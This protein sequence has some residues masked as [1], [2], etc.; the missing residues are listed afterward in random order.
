MP[1][2]EANASRFELHDV[3]AV[4]YGNG[5]MLALDAQ[6]AL[7]ACG[8]GT[9]QY[10][11]CSCVGNSEAIGESGQL[12]LGAAY[13]SECA[14]K[15]WAM[16]TTL[17]EHKVISLACGS[18]HSAVVTDTGDVF[19]WGRGFEGQTGHTSSKN[20]GGVPLA[21]TIVDKVYIDYLNYN[22]VL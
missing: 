6:G 17:Q 10:I 15:E 22:P 9:I 20:C 11:L 7:W 19:T 3:V 8:A 21:L 2:L 1:L 4:K 13:P 18:Q 14:L 16:V 12:G 5:H